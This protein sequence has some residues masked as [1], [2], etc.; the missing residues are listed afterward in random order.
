[1]TDMHR[2]FSPRQ[3]MLLYMCILGVFLAT[4]L[5]LAPDI[6]LLY[7]IA[8]VYTML[9]G[10]ACVAACALKPDAASAALLLGGAL[11]FSYGFGTINTEI[12]YISS[13]LDL[14]KLSFINRT[15][16]AKAT[17]LVL[18]STSLSCALGCMIRAPLACQTVFNKVPGSAALLFSA[19]ATLLCLGSIFTGDIRFNANI[20]DDYGTA[21]AL[22]QLTLTMIAPAAGLLAAKYD[23]LSKNERL[24]AAGMLVALVGT[25]IIMG[26]RIFLFTAV[27]CV[28]CYISTKENVKIL[29]ARNIIIAI[30]VVPLLLAAS[31][32]F[33]AM[34]MA[35]Y[36]LPEN[37]TVAS[38]VSEATAIL[39]DPERSGV[40][41]FTSENE[42]TR[43]FI[44][45]YLAETLKHQRE[46]GSLG[47]ELLKFSLAIVT[48]SIVWPEKG[49]FVALGFEETISHTHFGIPIWD[50]ANTL[51][52]TGLADFGIAGAIFLPATI[53]L[54]F[55]FL[56]KLV[57]RLAKQSNYTAPLVVGS[58]YAMLSVE[59]A[60]SSYFVFIRNLLILCVIFAAV[61]AITRVLFKASKR[62]DFAPFPTQLDRSDRQGKR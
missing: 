8:I 1:M 42:K 30:I 15:D 13:D 35:S 46:H 23:N 59:A 33:M 16:L 6:S 43:T 9:M 57:G 24:F 60:L 29:T 52:T 21:S 3:P 61:S 45:G 32:G 28:I 37:A 17:A 44:I 4:L 38:I 48:P 25:Q 14:T 22:G 56:P 7:Q 11:A 51:I 62:E 19:L 10:A 26:R 39:Q 36:S 50:G 41:D 55:S 34:R 5:A 2:T 20:A 18:M 31:R 47:G 27:T 53:G 49:K 58:I 12:R 40:D 54:I